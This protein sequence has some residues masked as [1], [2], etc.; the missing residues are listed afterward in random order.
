METVAKV[1]KPKRRGRPPK[2]ADPSA[3]AH[4]SRVLAQE[5][6]AVAKR[7]SKVVETFYELTSAGKFILCKRKAS[8][9]VHRVYVG[10]YGKHDDVTQKVDEL[11]TAGKLKQVK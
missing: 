11:R 1:E 7:G 8:G 3:P 9:S 4:E 10:K 2:K 6:D 5:Q